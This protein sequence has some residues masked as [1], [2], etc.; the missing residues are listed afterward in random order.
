MTGTNISV[1]GVPTISFLIRSMVEVD[2]M[3][4]LLEADKYIVVEVPDNAVVWAHTSDP[5][6]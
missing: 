3:G 5:K 4:G 2:P 6:Y 1:I